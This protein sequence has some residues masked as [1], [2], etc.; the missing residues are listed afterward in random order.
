MLLSFFSL[1]HDIAT[2]CAS[3]TSLNFHSWWAGE[4]RQVLQTRLPVHSSWSTPMPAQAPSTWDSGSSLTPGPR[5]V[6]PVPLLAGTMEGLRVLILFSLS[7]SPSPVSTFPSSSL[8]HFYCSWLPFKLNNPM[9][10]SLLWHH[11][12]KTLHLVWWQHSLS[13]DLRSE[14]LTSGRNGWDG[15]ERNCPCSISFWQSRS[16]EMGWRTWNAKCP[17]WDTELST[18]RDLPP[19]IHCGWWLRKK[20]WWSSASREK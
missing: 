9:K 8:S 20:G 19:S 10:V 13:C 12:I 2:A 11:K 16:N 6:H 4:Q 3:V 15:L 18:G 14:G 7:S 1:S 5:K 17:I